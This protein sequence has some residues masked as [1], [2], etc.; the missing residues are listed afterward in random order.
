M[1]DKKYLLL[2]C[3]PFV[4]T[5]SPFSLAADGPWRLNDALGINQGFG[6]SGTQ[7][8]RYEHISDNVQPGTS[9]NDQVLAIRT[10]LN[11]EYQRGSFSWQVEFADIRQELADEGS[12]L[13]NSTVNSLDFL[14]A[15]MGYTFGEDNNTN[16][17]LGRFSE[18]WGS[19]RLMARNRFRNSINAFDGLVVHHDL[20]S[21]A[22]LRFMATQ[23]VRR[24]PTDKPS[25][26]DNDHD[27][28]ESSD[29]QRFYGVHGSFPDLIEGVTS[30]FYLYSL[31][32]KDTADVRTRNRRLNTA[33]FRV[34]SGPSSGSYDFEIE[35]VIQNGQRRAS[36]AATDLTDLD[37][38][39]FFQYL[40]IGYSF[41]VPSNLRLLLEFDY[42][43]GDEDPFDQD[44]ERFDSLFGPTTF[45]FGVVG[46]YNPFNRSNLIT[47]GL[48]ITAD[49]AESVGFMASYRH[50]WLAEKR[51]SWGRTG[52]RDRSGESGSYLGQHLQLRLRW[53][54]IPGNLRI[55]TGA[56]LL[57]AKN[58][59]DK[60]SEYFY[61]GATFTF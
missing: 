39:A 6:L 10:I 27:S 59:S 4:V 40:G 43:T 47:P 29:A 25:L 23:V 15:N 53:D 33:G 16:V 9:A 1:L 35:T 55:E 21:G 38:R 49:L 7:R 41:D 19:R 30:E 31:R 45:E 52:I 3:I 36:T 48:R 42:A 61:T 60:S 50:F 58:L 2:L 37:H 44:N 18:D 8:T 34:R 56:I 51:D 12:V 5:C 57:Q 20:D 26:L 32:E 11:A 24:L 14:Q 13:G 46:L 22:E 54:V 28:D 17:R